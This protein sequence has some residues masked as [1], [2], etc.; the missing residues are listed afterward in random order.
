MTVSELAK[1]FGSGLIPYLATLA[2]T[3]GVTFL[4]YIIFDE[5]QA[6]K[7]YLPLVFMAALALFSVLASRQAKVKNCPRCDEL[8]RVAA[9][10]CKHCHADIEG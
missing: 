3:A 4:A 9:S 5:M 2:K 8:V 6:D 10:R 7:E 1:R